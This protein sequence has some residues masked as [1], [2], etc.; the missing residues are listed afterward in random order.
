MKDWKQEALELLE[1]IGQ[2]STR[3]LVTSDLRE[4]FREILAKTDQANYVITHYREPRAVLANVESFEAMRRLALLVSAVIGKSDMD[5]VE[6]PTILSDEAWEQRVS[7]ARKVS[8][9][10]SKR[11]R[12]PPRSISAS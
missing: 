11:P 8:R 10:E 12:R 9:Q 7:E 2:R 6:E 3:Q 4:N 5:Q 1:L